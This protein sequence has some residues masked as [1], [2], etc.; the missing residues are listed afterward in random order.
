MRRTGLEWT[1]RLAL[2]P[3]R[4]FRRYVMG[5]P[6][7]LARSLRLAAQALRRRGLESA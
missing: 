7:F 5:N 3:R 6:V 2:E 4:L 1:Y